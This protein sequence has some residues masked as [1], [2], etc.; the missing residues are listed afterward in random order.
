MPSVWVV[1]RARRS[2]K[3]LNHK[4]HA[5]A[6]SPRAGK[7]DVVALVVPFYDWSSAPVLMPYVYGVLDAA[8]QHA[9]N[10][11]LVTGDDDDAGDVEEVAR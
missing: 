1:A 10:V 2:I 8:R 9:W 11:T 4:P 3:E 5:V 7:T 6:R